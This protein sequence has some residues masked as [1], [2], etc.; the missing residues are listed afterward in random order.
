[1]DGLLGTVIFSIDDAT[2]DVVIDKCGPLW[3]YLGWC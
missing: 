2:T 1:M 3:R